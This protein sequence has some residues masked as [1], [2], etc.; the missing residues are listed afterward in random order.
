MSHFNFTNKSFR[1][2]TLIELLVVIAIIGLLSTVI[3]GPI[4]DARKKGR[5]AK[6][7]ADIKGIQF[8]ISQYY[9]DNGQYPATI[10]LLTTG[11]KKYLP[12]VPANAAAGLTA[13]AARDK[14]MY[15][16]YTDAV[17]NRAGY[18]LGVKLE[19]ANP[20]LGTDA[21]CVGA[22]CYPPGITSTS[23]S[24]WGAAAGTVTG[25]TTQPGN[26]TTDFDGADNGATTACVST[27]YTG[28]TSCV[29]DVVPG[30]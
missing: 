17:G 8:A 7:I 15:V 16:V 2:F 24:N 26:A 20:A 3:A 23:F 4:Q 29:F 19:T 6:K 27:G 25:T 30:L 18:H 12:A 21:D 13:A 22:T 5:D 9:D 1:G 28:A 11:T 10:D 14:Y